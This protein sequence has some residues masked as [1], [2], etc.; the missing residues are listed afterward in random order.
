MDGERLRLLSRAPWLGGEPEAESLSVSEVV[1]ACPVEPAKMF[2][3]GKNYLA[4]AKEMGGEVPEEPLVFAKLTSSLLGPGG[5]VILP[6]E[7]ARVDHEAEL[8]VVIGRRARRVSPADALSHV[9]GYTAICD[10]TA[11]DL[12]LKDK[13]WTRAK[14][15]DTFCPLGPTV[16]S[17]LDCSAVGV[18]L[19][20]N[21]E[22][23]Q[24]GNTRDM[25]FDVA[26]CVAFISAFCTLE[27]GDVIATGTP[28][29][30]GPLAP[31]DQVVVSVEGL[32]D[33][34]FTVAASD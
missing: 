22:L 18:R 17:G 32:D 13:Q 3:I 11:R 33:L 23:R 31:R 24:D 6:K 27:P 8:G 19:S 26:H 4:H 34:A 9:F 12:Q 25:A 1:L 14:G 2:G 16:V 21:G 7:S 15:F 30:I 20:V 5:T 29:G 10:V 28:D